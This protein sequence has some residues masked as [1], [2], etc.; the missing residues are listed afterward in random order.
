MHSSNRAR[1]VRTLQ[2]ATLKDDH[3]FWKSIAS[4]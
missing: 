2:L 1:L 3:D 4:F